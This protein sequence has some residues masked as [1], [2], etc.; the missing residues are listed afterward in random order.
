MYK[1][2][3]SSL[4]DALNKIQVW[5]Q[6]NYPTIAKSITPGLSLEEIQE[7]TQ[8]IPFTLPNEVYELYQWSRGHTQET[9]TIYTHIF[10]PY[11]GMAL[12]SLETA[13]EIAPTFEDEFEEC[14]VK[15]VDKPLF[16]IFQTDASYLCVVGDWEDKKS[17]PIIFVSDINEIGVVYTSL[18]DMMQTLLECFEASVVSFDQKGYSHW[19]TEKYAQVYLK[20]N[21]KL[22]D[23][24]L[25]RLKKELL[26]RQNDYVLKRMSISNFL[27]DIDRLDRERRKL[28][29]KQLDFKVIEP[30]VI[31]IQN[32]EQSIASLAQQALNELTT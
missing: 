15:Y 7:I 26:I 14:A 6:I 12:C 32:E 22:L 11:E 29:N 9:Q 5:L 8:I 25:Q 19:D 24:S 31:A 18:T 30:L 1:I 3:M 17:S 21:F 27:G 28:A 23:F 4:T 2:D 10:E 16:P 20:Y 13:I